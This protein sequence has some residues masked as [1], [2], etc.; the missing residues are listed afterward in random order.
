MSKFHYEDNIIMKEKQKKEKETL[1][2]EKIEEEDF[3]EM[4]QLKGVRRIVL[5]KLLNEKFY[6]PE[7]IDIAPH[8]TL[9]L[10][11]REASV[12]IDFVINLSSISFAVI[13]CVNSGLESW[14]RY[15]TA[16]ARAVKDYQIPYAMITDGNKA[17]TKDIIAGSSADSTM[18]AFFDRQRALEMIK[19]FQKIPCPDYRIGKEKRIVYA[20]QSI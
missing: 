9:K 14:E 8:F 4:M 7:E 17:L 6:R 20:F 1:I 11:D 15:V 16:F 3:A 18:E 2:R 12:S 5:E 10:E 19:D 13:K